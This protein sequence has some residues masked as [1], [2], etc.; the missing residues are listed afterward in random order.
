MAAAQ[1]PTNTETQPLEP[2]F[3]EALNQ[4]IS[5]LPKD[6]AIVGSV[7]KRLESIWMKPRLEDISIVLNRDS[8]I[9][10]G[11]AREM[12]FFPNSSNA[13]DYCTLIKPPT[14]DTGGTDNPQVKVQ[15]EFLTILYL[16]HIPHG[17]WPHFIEGFILSG[18]LDALSMSFTH[19][20]LYLRGQAVDAFLQITSSKSFDWWAPISISASGKQHSSRSQVALHL[21]LL[22][23]SK[24]EYF[25]PGLQVNA[26]AAQSWPGGPTQCLQLLAFWLSW[27]R[28]MY[29]IGQSLQLSRSLLASIQ[30]WGE[31]R[32]DVNAALSKAYEDIDTT[33]VPPE[34]IEF[35]SRMYNDFSREVPIEGPEFNNAGVRCPMVKGL[36]FLP[37]SDKFTKYL[38]PVIELGD[39]GS[40]DLSDTPTPPSSSSSSLSSSS[41]PPIPPESKFI[42]PV[43]RDFSCIVTATPQESA[44]ERGNK[45]FAAE[46]LETAL[47]AYNEALEQMTE[48]SEGRELAVVQ[49]NR[50]TVF[51]G[52][53]KRLEDGNLLCFLCTNILITFL[54]S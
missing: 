47:S 22:E 8:T 37:D 45:A 35:R 11:E 20:N 6:E 54:I 10:I 2:R 1:E 21:K 31:S 23:L 44:R 19:P 51:L 28:T 29:T 9:S 43:G 18:G 30:E 17:S 50:A 41:M 3:L 32:S 42:Q 33:I 53:S 7:R 13:K 49:C 24:S 15:I 36:V 27:C 26:D 38:E 48:V 5:S 52:L 34:L 4:V 39:N 40:F 14:D 46:D 16:L 25:I 12:I